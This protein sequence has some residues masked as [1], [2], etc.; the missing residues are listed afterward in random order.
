MDAVRL[1][2]DVVRAYV[3]ALVLGTVATAVW[4]AA[5]ELAETPRVASVWVAV[6]GFGL[7]V[8]ATFA[9]TQYSRRF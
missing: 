5:P 4:L 6:S 3:Y 2:H 8:L 7:L 1:G 9:V